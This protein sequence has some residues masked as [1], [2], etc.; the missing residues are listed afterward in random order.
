[1]KVKPWPQGVYKC[2]GDYRKESFL[3]EHIGGPLY[4]NQ[5]QLPRLPIP[6]LKETIN[7]FL[8]TA[9]PLAKTEAEALA[10]KRACDSFPEEADMLQQ[11]L[12]ARRGKEMKDSSW[13]QLWWNQL[14]YLHVRDPIVVNVS[15]F[16]SF[17]DD[18]TVK[19]S[20]TMPNIQR[21][22]AI[23]FAA[24]KYR[25]KVITGRLQ[26]GRVGRKKN[27]LCSTAYK[28]MFNACR[29]PLQ[30]QD[31]YWIYDPSMYTHFVVAR[32]GHFFSAELVDQFGEPLSLP[33]LEKQLERCIA[34][35]DAA[36]SSRPKFG[37]LTS[38]N[39]DDWASDRVQLVECGGRKMVQ[40][41]EKL[42]SGALLLNLDDEAPVS[43]QECGNLFW[44]GGLNSGENRWFDKSIQ[45]IVCNNGKA[46]LVAEHSMMDGMPV[47][48]LADAL[49]KMTYALAREQSD[50][51]LNGKGRVFDIFESAIHGA[52]GSVVRKLERNGKLLSYHASFLPSSSIFQLSVGPVSSTSH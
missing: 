36:P 21:G 18:P 9:L 1:M 45:V 17:I 43:R 47:V 8:P 15:Y 5:K 40:A 25:K 32:K 7:R 13:L 29:I 28:Y 23:L 41:L 24:A 38:R 3:E 37:L 39:R 49:C 26:P 22:A 52:K 11:K 27:I 35:A 30:G 14:G 4:E 44:T 10:L 2:N 19:A 48:G 51:S 50:V 33:E 42:Q 20:G 31:S 12:R 46:G 16:F 34:I 6:P